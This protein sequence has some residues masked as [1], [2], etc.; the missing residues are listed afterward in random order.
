[1]GLS[2]TPRDRCGDRAKRRGQFCV[3]DVVEG[4]DG[5]FRVSGFGP[6]GV[7]RGIEWTSARKRRGEISVFVDD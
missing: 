3:A 2:S 7:L 1:M 4:E 6:A 5:Q